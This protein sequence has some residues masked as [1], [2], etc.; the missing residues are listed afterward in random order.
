MK[1]VAEPAEW[2]RQEDRALVTSSECLDPAMP[3]ASPTPGLAV[4]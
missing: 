2:K 1:K 3:E 4:S